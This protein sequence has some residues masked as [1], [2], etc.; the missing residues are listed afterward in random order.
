MDLSFGRDLAIR[1]ARAAA[2]GTA[3]PRA[4]DYLRL[5]AT[6]ASAQSATRTAQTAARLRDGAGAA[7]ADGMVAMMDPASDWIAAGIAL[8]GSFHPK[9]ARRRQS[10]KAIFTLEG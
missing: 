8:G 5:I 1:N 7:R 10:M 3:M 6:L 4:L 9:V 2:A